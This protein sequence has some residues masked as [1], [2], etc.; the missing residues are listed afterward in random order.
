MRK[1]EIDH[2][3]KKYLSGQ[4]SE[5]ENTIV[6]EWLRAR[7]SL[8]AWNWQDQKHRD[9]VKEAML[10][11]IERR[12]SNAG[13][14]PWLRLHTIKLIAAALICT[15]AVSFWFLKPNDR[16]PP[17]VAKAVKPGTRAAILQIEGA[18]PIYLDDQ[19]DGQLKSNAAI[20][21]QK[22]AGG[23]L[24]Y[25]NEEKDVTRVV[26]NTL[27]IPRGG[28]YQVRLSDGT[29][30]WL[31][32]ET[33]L[34][35]PS[36]FSGSE[37]RVK[38]IGEAYF[39]VKKDP[40]RPF[41]VVSKD[42]DV[43]VTGTEFN[44]SAYPGAPENTTTLVEGGVDIYVADQLQMKLRPGQQAY[45]TSSLMRKRNVDAL[46]VAS[47]KNGYFS[48]QYETLESVMDE[49]SRW[50]DI[51]YKIIGQPVHPDKLGGTFSREKSLDELLSYIEQLI[52]VKITRKERSVIIRY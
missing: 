33:T 2:L 20:T 18:E 50:Y 24:Q 43:R 21:I 39:D 27:S 38:I 26:E 8:N 15:L 12:I 3:L 52:N 34:S 49:V 14:T 45:G 6:E 7:S 19:S 1:K 46:D 48:F 17:P 25:A 28:Q 13:Q 37:R 9:S 4:L 5:A 16:N 47:W 36:R 44:I 40:A 30:V 11:E 35:Y 22:I 10:G 42:L 51:D 32:S 31:N 41:I 23:I 29:I